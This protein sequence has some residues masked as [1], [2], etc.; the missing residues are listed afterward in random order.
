MRTI[1]LSALLLLAGCQ[2]AYYSAM[3]QVGYHKREIL[4][5][6]VED[7]QESQEDAQKQFSSALEEMKTLVDF[8][9]GDLEDAYDK[10]K[11][12]YDASA[13]AA[14]QVSSRINGVADVADAM[15]EEWQGELEEYQS[16]SLRRESQTQLRETRQRYDGML[17][18]MRQAESKMEPVLRRL[19]D[20]ELYLKHNL[21]ARAIGAVGNEFGQ[22]EVEIQ[23]VIDEMNRAIAESDQF[24]QTLQ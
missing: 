14:E 19:K 18:A 4:V 24:I 10:V 12:Q 3:E 21:N 15:F 23:S 2:S 5:D 6:R 11:S 20:N 13:S 17:R 9:G 16:A 8:D 7:A 22:L 1:L